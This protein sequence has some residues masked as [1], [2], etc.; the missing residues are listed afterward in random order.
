MTSLK[1]LLPER[2]SAEYNFLVLAL[3]DPE[4]AK[5]TIR[6]LDPED[7]YC[8]GFRT[9]FEV[10]RKMIDEDQCLS[11]TSLQESVAQCGL[12]DRVGGRNFFA[13]LSGS[14]AGPDPFLDCERAAG[15]MKDAALI[16]KLIALSLDAIRKAFDPYC[17]AQHLLG[18]VRLRLGELAEA[19]RPNG[20]GR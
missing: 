11:I 9:L 8:R 7:F 19:C 5:P 10:M 14:V 2:P 4:G 6:L 18:Q 20:G 15:L 17:D 13:I 16:R 1:P 3:K 12:L